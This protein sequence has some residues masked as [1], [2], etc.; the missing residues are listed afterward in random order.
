MREA[1]RNLPRYIAG[2]AQGKRFLFAWQ[3]ATICPS[4]LTNVFAFDDDYAMGILTSVVHQTWAHSESSTLEDRPRY[5]PTTCFETFP[6]PAPDRDQRDRIAALTAE[7]I[8]AR[9]AITVRDGIGLTEF[10]NAV[11]DGA[12]HEISEL[13]REL[14]RAVLS[15]YGY[16]DAL[17]SDPLEL[18]ARLAA[19]HGEIASGTRAYEPFG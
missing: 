11:D 5:T 8:E 18:K 2:N 3:E 7:L 15:A 14:D 16:P 1:I 17:R 6:W 9:Q 10:Y 13:H 19:L 4:N 12:W